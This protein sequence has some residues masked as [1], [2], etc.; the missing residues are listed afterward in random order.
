VKVSFLEVAAAEFDD[1]VAYYESEHPGLGSR[2]RS[3]VSRAVSRITSYPSAYQV[4]SKRTRRCLIAK[5][6][7]GII[8]QHKPSENEVVIIAVAHLHRKPD[9]WLS[10]KS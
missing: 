5:F 9:Y 8:F 4:L 2:F 7:Y 10:R 1:A 6:P 3:E